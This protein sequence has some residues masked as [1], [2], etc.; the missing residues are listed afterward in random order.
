MQV[1]GI[2]NWASSGGSGSYRYA[3]L[4]VSTPIG[5]L[6]VT[7]VAQ[8]ITAQRSELLERVRG[9]GGL[10]SLVDE[11][12]GWASPRERAV[13]YAVAALT[14]AVTLGD[15]EAEGMLACLKNVGE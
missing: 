7:H 1:V 11:R 6:P 10:A 5:A 15:R 3:E 12:G 2:G 13:A 9:G 14:L 4:L 8:A